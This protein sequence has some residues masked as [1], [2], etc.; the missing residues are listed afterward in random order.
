MRLGWLND[1][2]STPRLGAEREIGPLPRFSV[3][4]LSSRRPGETRRVAGTV[5]NSFG[6]WIPHATE[7]ELLKILNVDGGKFG[8]A[9][10]QKR[11]RQA[12]VI[13]STIAES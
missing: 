12:S 4:G 3:A 13:N 9:V 2:S 8:D 1:V 11:Q 7:P 5:L 6:E 10:L